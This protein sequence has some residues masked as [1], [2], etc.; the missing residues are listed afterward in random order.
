M[1]TYTIRRRLVSL[2]RSYSVFGEGGELAFRLT[3]NVRFARTFLLRSRSGE[4]PLRAR[5]K[6][7]AIDPTFIITRNRA[8][9]A[10]VCRRTTSG[11]VV[12]R[13][14]ITLAS[15]TMDGSGSLLSDDGV[16]VGRGGSVFVRVWRVH[17]ELRE[18]FRVETVTTLEQAL[19]LAVAMSIVDID[20]G[21]GAL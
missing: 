11:A 19:L 17:G 10:T 1:P 13:F 4:A 14:E 3:G 8:E 2:A 15:E 20:P 21:R 9:V 7:L 16:R 12:D 18:T 6:L 5:E